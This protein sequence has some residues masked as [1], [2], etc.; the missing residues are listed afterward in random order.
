[1]CERELLELY[2]RPIVRMKHCIYPNEFIGFLEDSDYGHDDDFVKHIL[3][4]VGE[5]ERRDK[6]EKSG[7]QDE[8]ILG[9]LAFFQLL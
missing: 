5:I 6:L 7:I 4:V 3:A 2:M 8:N 9:K 1:M